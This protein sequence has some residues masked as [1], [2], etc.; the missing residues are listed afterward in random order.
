MRNK[1]QPSR[2]NQPKTNKTEDETIELI[3]QLTAFEDFQGNIL[4]ALQKDV[5]N[6]LST[7]QLR[8]KYASLVQA[9][10]ITAALANPDDG[11]ALAAAT[12]LINRV[13]GK[14]TEKKEVTHTLANA[15]DKEIDAILRSELEELEDMQE[16]FEQ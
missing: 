7:K 12:D 3:D 10:I 16:R 9:R 15:S 6:G 11:K 8:E 1:A 5:K 2:Y 14:P 13:E 4:P